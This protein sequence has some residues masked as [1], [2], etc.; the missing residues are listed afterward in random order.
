[1]RS[2][3]MLAVVTGALVL[4]SACSDGGST[5]P[6]ANVAPVAN[7]TAPSC[8]INVPCTFTSTSTDDVAVTGWSWDFNGDG[9]PDATTQDAAFTYTTAGNF[10]VILTVTDGAGLTGTKIAV[11]TIAPVT[12]VNTPPTAGFTASCTAVNCTF[13]NTSTDVAPGTIASY[14]WN[15][16]D[17]SAT[18]NEKDPTH[19]YAVTAATPFTVT[20]TV[21]DN[22]GATDV[23][24]QTVTVTPAP[25]SSQQCIA[26]GTTAV[27]CTLGITARSTVKL[28]L[29]GVSCELGA[30]RINITQPLPAKLAFGNVCSKAVGTEYTIPDA[31][32]APM[33]FEAG[34]QV[35][36]RFT[37]GVGD[38]GDPALGVPRANLGGTSPTWTISIE[39]GGNPGGPNE[40]DF[41]DVVLVVQ[42]T[43]AP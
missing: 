4:A 36:V 32:G 15:F 9:T 37:Q 7:F 40:P 41:N 30:S 20:L 19:T 2:I 34:T 14:L 17:G 42:A 38:P 5:A 21:T 28:T 31:V 22:E 24:T 11:V 23:E 35:V 26:A 8:T 43:R 18:S 27:D 10:S 25:P 16:G 6:P 39:D 33:V 13:T 29:T 12:P 1:M 3:R